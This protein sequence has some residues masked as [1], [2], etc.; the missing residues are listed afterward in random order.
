MISAVLYTEGGDLTGFRAEGHSGYAEEGSDIVCA[1]VSVLGCTCVNS[2]EEFLGVRVE[3]HGN[4][5]GL[6]DFSLPE[7]PEEKRHDAQLLMKALRRGLS[8]IQESYPEYVKIKIEGRR[9]KR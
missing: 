3:E 7:I 1:A 8:D 2:L 5:S 4:K 9:K 6:L